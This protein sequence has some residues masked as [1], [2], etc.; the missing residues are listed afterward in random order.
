ML[1]AE[2]GGGRGRRWRR[3]ERFYDLLVPLARLIV[4]LLTNLRVVGAE[5]V[6]ARGGVLLA[7]NHVSFL[8]R[9]FLRSPCMTAAAARCASRPRRPVRSPAG[10][11]GPAWHADGPGH[12]RA[13]GGPHGRRRLRGPGCRAGGAGLSRGHDRPARSDPPS[14]ARHRPGCLT[15]KRPGA[16]DRLPRRRAPPAAAPPPGDRG[17]RPPVDLSSC[18]GRLDRQARWSEHRTA[19]QRAGPAP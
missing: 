12:P 5:R 14:P 11:L 10:W 4:W 15:H 9:S 3:S 17:D 19:D 7:A 6:P 8:T 1:A 2:V 16:A 13:R 18:H